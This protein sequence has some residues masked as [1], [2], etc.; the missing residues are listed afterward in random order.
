MPEYLTAK[1]HEVIEYLREHGP[2]R[3]DDLADA[4]DTTLRGHGVR[5]SALTWK[6]GHYVHCEMRAGGAGNYVWKA[7]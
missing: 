6:Q 5:L 4:L 3:Q 1:Q 7:S 2:T